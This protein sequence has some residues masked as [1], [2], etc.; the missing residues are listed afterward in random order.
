MSGGGSGNGERRPLTA[1]S[2]NDDTDYDIEPYDEKD[3]SQTCC[4][5]IA[6][7]LGPCRPGS[8]VAQSLCLCFTLSAGLVFLSLAVTSCLTVAFGGNW[9]VGE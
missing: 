7:E 2:G 3:H 9:I 8:Q 5:W 4:R 1:P 6:R